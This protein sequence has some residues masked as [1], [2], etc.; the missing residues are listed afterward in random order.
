MVIQNASKNETYISYTN[1]DIKQMDSFFITIHA[2]FV[3]KISPSPR[4]TYSKCVASGSA[5]QTELFIET[6]RAV[7]K[8]ES[9][10]T[11][12]FENSKA[13]TKMYRKSEYDFFYCMFDKT[14]HSAVSN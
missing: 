7:G 8:M 13:I 9:A 3:L 5:I 4:V 2:V 11:E 1:R 6:D 10:S 14:F 12:I